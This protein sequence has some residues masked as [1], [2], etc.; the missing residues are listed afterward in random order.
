MLVRVALVAMALCA[1]AASQAFGQGNQDSP[2][3]TILDQN[4]VEGTRIE[5]RTLADLETGMDAFV[6]SSSQ[7]RTRIRLPSSQYL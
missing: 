2:P 6:L 3:A 5:E 7:A 1:S 4:S